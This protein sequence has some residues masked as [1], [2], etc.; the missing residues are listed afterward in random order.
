MPRKS[1]SKSKQIQIPQLPRVPN[2]IHRGIVTGFDY[3][4]ITQ[5]NLSKPIELISLD[6]DDPCSEDIENISYN[7]YLAVNGSAIN[8][9]KM[10]KNISKKN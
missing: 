5:N 4:L 3:M 10:L 2:A 9:I 7:E 1:K 6:E 8:A